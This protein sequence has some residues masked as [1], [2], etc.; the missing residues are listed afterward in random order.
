MKKTLEELRESYYIAISRL[1]NEEDI[2]SS[3]PSSTCDSFEELINMIMSKLDDE[4]CEWEHED[5]LA[6]TASDKELVNNEL[7]ILTLKKRIC[8][9]KLQEYNQNNALIEEYEKTPQKHLIF[10]TSNLGNVFFLRDLKDVSEEYFAEIQDLLNDLENN[11]VDVMQESKDKKLNGLL[12]DIF[13]KKAF[14]IRICYRMLTPDTCYI[15]SVKMKKSTRDTKYN[16][17]IENR[18]I[19]T[20]N[21]YQR[22]KKI[23]QDPKSREDLINSN[24][25]IKKEIEKY[26]KENGRGGHHYGI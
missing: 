24:E 11:N 4:I 3:L 20:E 14:K 15:M 23:L 19:N 5:L 9:E 13:E 16:T 25:E 7:A 6:E 8:L 12:S 18:K 17:E 1:D 10:A 2:K 26:I 22:V 21:D